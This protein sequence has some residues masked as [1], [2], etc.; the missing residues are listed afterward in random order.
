M[1]DTVR[2]G[3]IRQLKL[4]GREFEPV[5]EASFEFT[6]SGY[7]HE[8]KA[9][10][11][12]VMVGIE[13]RVLAAIDGI[14]V[15]IDNDRGDLEYLTDLKNAG[16]PFAV[17]CTV[18]GGKTWSGSMAIEGELKYSTAEGKAT[19]ALRGPRLEQI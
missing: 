7:D 9:A 5:D 8:N 1:G 4:K 2:G 14:E 18:A 12:G 16:E 10:G 3:G 13:K 11:N 15:Y 17:N 19:F 6:P